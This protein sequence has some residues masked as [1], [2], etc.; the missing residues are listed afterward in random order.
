MVVQFWLVVLCCLKASVMLN[1]IAINVQL[2]GSATAA[3]NGARTS[4]S[5]WPFAGA[6]TKAKYNLASLATEWGNDR[7]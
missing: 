7:K 5:R 3:C 4:G 2:S 6:S 1:L